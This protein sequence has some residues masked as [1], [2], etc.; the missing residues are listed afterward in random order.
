MITKF[1]PSYGAAYA[2]ILLSINCAAF[3]QEETQP[4][5][6]ESAGS[7]IGGF[8]S[9]LKNDLSDAAK[10]ISDNAKAPAKQPGA[11]SAPPPGPHLKDT[12]LNNLF[13]AHPNDGSK[14]NP[15][16][17]GEAWFPRVALIPVTVPSEHRMAW[18]M[19]RQTD[20][21]TVINGR[22]ANT[23]NLG[24]M[25]H[26]QFDHICYK[27]KAKIWTTPTKSEEVPEFLF[28][29]DEAASLVPAGGTPPD[30]ILT[31]LWM[32]KT[33]SGSMFTQGP[34]QPQRFAG[35]KFMQDTDAISGNYNAIISLAVMQK[36]GLDPFDVYEG[37][38]AWIADADFTVQDY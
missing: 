23:I 36:M 10:S 38:R 9:K 29:A 20:G 12:K 35:R 28:C 4:A 13:A 5:G 30:T 1:K 27:F 26:T 31:H 15:R 21:T 32:S 19:D 14:P 22:V 17:N 6:K 16:F 3:A 7:M 11:Q 33:Q 2:A 8:F 37:N 25:G 34:R 18:G 24:K